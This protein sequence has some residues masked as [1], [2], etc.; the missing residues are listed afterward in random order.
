[1][2]EL[3]RRILAEENAAAQAALR[4]DLDALGA[5]YVDAVGKYGEVQG[6]L[7]VTGITE[8]QHKRDLYI[9]AYTIV[10]ADEHVSGAERVY[11]AQ[12]AHQLG[13]DPATVSHLEA[14]TGARIDASPETPE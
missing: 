8:N 14:E 4:A 1:M 12:L 9:L 5:S 2:S 7:I 10:R 11:L 6:A 13:L 3:P